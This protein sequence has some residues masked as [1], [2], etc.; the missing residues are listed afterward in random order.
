MLADIVFGNKVGAF[1]RESGQ[2]LRLLSVLQLLPL[3]QFAPFLQLLLVLLLKPG[4]FADFKSLPS[5]NE[6]DIEV[7]QNSL[8]PSSRD[9]V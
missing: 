8:L 4:V 1:L 3:H 2:E 7:D 9:R 5:H 6:D